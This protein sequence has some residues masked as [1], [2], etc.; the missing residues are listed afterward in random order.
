MSKHVLL[1][2]RREE[3]VQWAEERLV[4]VKTSEG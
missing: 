4:G 1:P 3:W 2:G